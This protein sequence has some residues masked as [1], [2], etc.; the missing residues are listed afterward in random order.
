MGELKV[1]EETLE[2]KEIREEKGKA[3]KERNVESKSRCC[4]K[5]YGAINK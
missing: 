3:Q 4:V 1:R 2:K 5:L